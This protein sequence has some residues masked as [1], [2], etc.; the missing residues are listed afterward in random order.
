MDTYTQKNHYILKTS[1]IIYTIEYYSA[2][3]KDAFDSVLM[4]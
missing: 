2:K 4:R 3:K 1:L